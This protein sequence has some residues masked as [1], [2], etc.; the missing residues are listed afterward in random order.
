MPNARIPVPPAPDRRAA[1]VLRSADDRLYVGDGDGH[2][3]RVHWARWDAERRRH[4][5]VRDPSVATHL[6]FVRHDGARR[7]APIPIGTGHRLEDTAV[8]AHLGGA[9]WLPAGLQPAAPA[10]DASPNPPTE[11]SVCERPFKASARAV[12]DPDWLR[13]GR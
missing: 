6:L 4:R 10:A 3:W 2:L 1:G 13:G 8:E 11:R 7:A 9:A 5:A 12:Q